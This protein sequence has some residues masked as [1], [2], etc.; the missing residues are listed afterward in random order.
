[1][2]VWPAAVGPEMAGPVAEPKIW[3]AVFDAPRRDML[4]RCTVP[5]F[6]VTQRDRRQRS[7]SV[8]HIGAAGT[9]AH[10]TI[11]FRAAR[12]LGGKVSAS[13]LAAGAGWQAP[14]TP[15]TAA[16]APRLRCR[17]YQPRLSGGVTLDPKPDNVRRSARLCTC[18]GQC[19]HDHPPSQ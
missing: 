2:P 1:M 3:T 5:R 18:L 15:R 10:A 14:H 9:V 6:A 7:N 4:R 13:T 11:V 16:V 8:F 17:G 12:L 19:A